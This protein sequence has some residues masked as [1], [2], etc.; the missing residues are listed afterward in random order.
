MRVYT[1]KIDPKTGKFILSNRYTEIMR[2]YDMLEDAEIPFYLR[3][4]MDG[5][6][7]CYPVYRPQ[8][9][10]VCSCI[11]HFG[12]YGG[13]AN[14]L[15]IMGLLTPEEHEADSV[16]GWLSAENVFNRIAAHW[17]STKEEHHD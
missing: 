9:E 4:N 17:R 3:R 5:W 2:L 8:E 1:P 13:T 11:Q 6:Q 12:S 16:V 14:T 7:I 15:E 10:C